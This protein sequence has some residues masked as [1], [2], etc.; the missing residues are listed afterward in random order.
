MHISVLFG[1]SIVLVDTEKVFAAG[2]FTIESNTNTQNI[3]GPF[4]LK[5]I[6]LLLGKKKP[7]L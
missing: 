5:L 6:R 1:T 2:Q 4:K 7:V 3:N